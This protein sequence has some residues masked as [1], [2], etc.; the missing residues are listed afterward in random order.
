LEARDIVDGVLAGLS[1]EWFGVPDGE[2]VVGGGW[3]WRADDHP[4][5]P[6]HF[7]SPSRYM[8]QPNPGP[9]AARI[10]EQHG[11]ATNAAV[12]RFLHTQGN[13]S[14]RRLGKI[15]NALFEAFSKDIDLLTS[16]L[17]GVMMGF[18][19]TVDGNI[20][21]ALYEWVSNP[22]LWD[23]QLEYLADDAKDSLEKAS[24]ILMRRLTKTLLLRSVPE[25]AWRTALVRHSLGV[26]EVNPG[27]RIVV[28]IVSATQECLMKDEVDADGLYFIFGGNRSEKDH[29]THACPGYE[30]AIGVM[31]GMLAGLLGSTR[32]RPTMSPLQLAVSTLLG[33]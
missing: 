1:A 9:E 11:Q 30:M 2:Y 8:F 6:G 14:A 25:L 32:L 3:H 4:T 12:C 18:L 10:G 15:G 31:L 16:T 26:V 19:P 23:Y 13:N 24:R 29:P 20:R 22:S 27:D 17:I 7:H 5:C 28:S 33:R 21:G